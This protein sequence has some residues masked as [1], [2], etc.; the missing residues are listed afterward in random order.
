MFCSITLT[1]APNLGDHDFNFIFEL[2]AKSIDESTIKNEP[3]QTAAPVGFVSFA[4]FVVLK[5]FQMW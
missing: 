4:T 2:L 3:D 1:T 5:H